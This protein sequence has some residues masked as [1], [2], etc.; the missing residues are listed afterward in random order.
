MIGP[1]AV[2]IGFILLLILIGFL[3]TWLY[4]AKKQVLIEH[5]GTDEAVTIKTTSLREK[6]WS[7]LIRVAAFV[8]PTAMK[9]P[10]FAK[11]EKDEMILTRAGHPMGIT[12]S[13]VYG[14]RYFLSFTSFFILWF[15]FLLGMPFGLF[16]LVTVPVFMFF[17]PIIWIHSQAKKRQEE[18]SSSMPDFLDTV[19]I[20]L[21]AGVSLEI[22][23]RQV[24]AIMKG[25]LSEEFQQFLQ[26][27]SLGVPRRTAFQNLLTRNNAKELEIL[28]HS[29]LQGI[30]LG[31]PISNVFRV[32]SED[33][34]ATRGYT[35]KEKAA[36]ASPKV[37]LIA[38]FIITPSVLLLIVGLLALNYV[39]NPQLLG[40][41]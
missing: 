13:H 40:L 37:T 38:T 3:Y 12:L 18:I 41:Q 23:L 31:V 27:I 1:V 11:P 6:L 10:L 15:C 5:V 26:Q 21:Q 35:A 25:P 4:I 24:T 34:R 16:F 39:Y 36:K 29:L 14:M 30:E 22:A 7:P 33:L 2:L 17:L 8:G 19:S 9:Y 32:Q 20:T 28:V